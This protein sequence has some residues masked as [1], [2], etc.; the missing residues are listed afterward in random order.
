LKKS[1]RILW[2]ILATLFLGGCIGGA[3]WLYF[4]FFSRQVPPQ[5]LVRLEEADR[6]IAKGY[7]DL[8]KQEL[9]AL[10][11]NAESSYTLLRILKRM[12]QLT[13]LTQDWLWLNHYTLAAYAARPGNQDLAFLA[14]YTAYKARRLDEVR[15]IVQKK[16]LAA[17]L[18]VLRLA[19]LLTLGAAAEQQSSLRQELN[20]D[21]QEL[22]DLLNAHD[23]LLFE[24]VGTEEQ[25]NKLLLDAALLWME[26]GEVQKAYTLA[27]DHLAEMSFDEPAAAICYEAGDLEGARTRLNALLGR[28]K[29]RVDLLLFIGDTWL[30]EGNYTEAKLYYQLLIANIPKLASH[31][32]LNLA[33]ILQHEGRQVEALQ[34]LE[35]GLVLFP[36]EGMLVCETAKLKILAGAEDEAANLLQVYLKQEPDNTEAWFILLALESKRLKPEYFQARLWELFERYPYNDNLCEYLVWHLLKTKDYQKAG[37]ALDIFSKA[38]LAGRMHAAGSADKPQ[39]AGAAPVATVTGTRTLANKEQE[40]QPLQLAWYLHLSGLLYALQGHY[41]EAL[42]PISRSL[43]I[44]EEV[45][46]RYNRAILHKFL[47]DYTKAKADVEQALA[48]FQLIAPQDEQQQ[49]IFLARV[50]TLRGELLLNEN[51][52]AN[53]R[54][55]LLYALE[56]DPANANAKFLLNKL[57]KTK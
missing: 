36:R 40:Q 23:P 33:W 49:K 14:A 43:T 52:Y 48:D 46:V 50:H 1:G 7:L 34:I 26:R 32:Y 37:M 25:E 9:T 15:S 10:Y 53:A 31:P 24:A 29:Q 27:R 38:S 54:D 42:E 16:P 21:E 45:H 5:V 57:E 13:R 47:K 44:K 35:Q 55:A 4:A 41:A 12:V 8:A 51:S 30:L 39:P 17:N 3:F 2:A 18:N 11:Q 28:N 20:K 22:L 6:Y 19:T 56:C